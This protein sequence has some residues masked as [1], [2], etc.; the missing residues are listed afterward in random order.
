MSIDLNID[1]GRLDR[2]VTEQ[3]C[4]TFSAIREMYA[5]N[6]YL[7]LFDVARIT[8]QAGIDA[9]GNRGMFTVFLSQLCRDVVYIEPQL[10]FRQAL[11]LLLRDNPSSCKVHIENLFLGGAKAPGFITVPEILSKY[12]LSRVTLCK[13]DVEGA[14]FDVFLGDSS[15]LKSVDNIAMEVHGRAGNPH[16][17]VDTLVACGFRVTARDA[18]LRPVDPGH[19]DYICASRTGALL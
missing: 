16:V 15:W 18:S 8:W 19:A 10:H 5:R 13:F 11:Q 7:R 12:G 14:E 1:C 3:T 2:I 4:S 9:G 6:V 17:L